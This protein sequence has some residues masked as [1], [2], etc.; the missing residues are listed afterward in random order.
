MDANPWRES[1][2]AD[3]ELGNVAF[4][5]PCPSKRRR[6]VAE[7]PTQQARP[8]WADHSAEG[9]RKDLGA[10]GKKMVC[11]LYYIIEK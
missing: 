2:N 8:A 10:F 4:L 6:T 5:T 3:V 1:T 7:A 9:D 11:R